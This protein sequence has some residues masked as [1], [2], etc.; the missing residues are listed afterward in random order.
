MMR[1]IV[2]RCLFIGQL[3]QSNLFCLRLIGRVG[4]D[5]IARAADL[6][7]EVRCQLLTRDNFDLRVMR[8][9]LQ[10]PREMPAKAIIAAQWISVTDD[11]YLRHC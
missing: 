2:T 8:F 7:R 4:K 9:F 10:T 5:D 1:K 6:F 3:A 11:Q